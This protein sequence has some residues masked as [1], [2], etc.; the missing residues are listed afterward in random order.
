MLFIFRKLR[1]SFFLPG[2]VRSYAA[3]AIGEIALI[4]VGILVALQINNWNEGRKERLEERQILLQ[5]QLQVTSNLNSLSDY[6]LIL[7]EAE[8]ALN[9][10]D[11]ALGSK[12]IRDNIEFLN[13]V[14]LSS[15]F[16][17]VTSIDGL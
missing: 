7:N 11:I 14:S 17:I 4:V 13:D 12:D 3:Y 5:M 2:K 10:V 9:R 15:S 8:L 16:G 1:K 6:L